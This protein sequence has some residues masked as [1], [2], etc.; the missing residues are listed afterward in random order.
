MTVERR[1]REFLATNAGRQYC[2]DCLSAAL[3]IKPR[4][5]VHQKTSVLGREASF[6]R[7][8]GICARCHSDRVVVEAIVARATPTASRLPQPSLPAIRP[9]IAALESLTASEMKY[10]E[11][12]R[13]KDRALRKF[14]DENKI[15][16]PVD[17]R[18]LL[19]YLVRMKHVLGNINNDVGFAAT[20][21]VKRYL[22]E[23]FAISDFDAAE[24]AQ[25]ASGI[26]VEART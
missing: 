1:I 10:C 23:R 2:D 3:Q 14:L 25:G 4:Q 18:Q 5:Q 17:A 19:S 21:M 16:E 26:D 13:A 9:A 11:V 6:R 22:E 24:K 12:I 20:L 8:P 15:A 7:A